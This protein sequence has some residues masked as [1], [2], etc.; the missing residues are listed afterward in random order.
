MI[1]AAATVL[2]S[3]NQIYEGFQPLLEVGQV[4]LEAKMVLL[5]LLLFF[6]TDK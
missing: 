4:V 2:Y 3:K 1:D 6:G 5:L